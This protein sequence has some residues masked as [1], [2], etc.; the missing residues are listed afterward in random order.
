[1]MKKFV[2]QESEHVKIKQFSLKEW[3]Q[4]TLIRDFIRLVELIEKRQSETPAQTGPIVIHC[5]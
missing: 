3:N 1:M 2:S 5:L 4:S